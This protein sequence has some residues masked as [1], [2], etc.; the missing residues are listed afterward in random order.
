MLWVVLVFGLETIDQA[1]P[2]HSSVNV[3]HAWEL[4]YS[5]TAMQRLCETHDT[6]CSR[7]LSALP[8]GLGRRVQL[9]PFHDS[10]SVWSTP[11][12]AYHPTAMHDVAETHETE[13]NSFGCTPLLSGLAT[14]AQLAPCVACAAIERVTAVRGHAATGA[15]RKVVA[16]TMSA[17]AARTTRDPRNLEDRDTPAG[18]QPRAISVPDVR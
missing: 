7:L 17:V 4:T 13:R 12:V 18:N 11:P 16:H 10:I 14:T 1:R 8:F 2:S 9:S 5:P 3:R 15:A 6:E